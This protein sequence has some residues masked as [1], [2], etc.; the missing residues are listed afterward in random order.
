MS[1]AEMA[2]AL[3]E[4]LWV[5]IK[6]GGPLLVLTLVIGL[7]VSLVQA[8]TQ[9]NESTLVFLPKLFVV[10]GTLALLGPFMI[11]TLDAYTHSLMDR[12][13]AVGGR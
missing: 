2:A 3:R 11:Q 5:V 6:L 4:T 8:V 1:E 10:C 9:V 7:V 13:I 12:V